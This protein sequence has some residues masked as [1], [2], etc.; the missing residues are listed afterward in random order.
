MS[1]SGL[2][3][4]L[5]ASTPAAEL[6]TSHLSHDVLGYVLKPMM[7]QIVG[8]ELLTYEPNW[9]LDE[10]VNASVVELMRLASRQTKPAPVPHEYHRKRCPRIK[11]DNRWEATCTCDMKNHTVCPDED[12]YRCMHAN[13]MNRCACKGNPPPELLQLLLRE[14]RRSKVCTVEEFNRVLTVA[15][16]PNCKDLESRLRKLGRYRAHRDMLWR[17]IVQLN[18]RLVLY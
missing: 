5:C 2:I 9:S 3:D 11:G 1:W 12:E 8:Q 6:W 18:Q 10:F 15:G 4:E 16:P 17:N 14:L 7:L 13:Y